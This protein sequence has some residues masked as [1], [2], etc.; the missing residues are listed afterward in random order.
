MF[1]VSAWNF[2]DPRV[3]EDYILYVSHKEGVSAQL[4]WNIAKCE[5]KFNPLAHNTNDPNGGSKGVFQF[6]T[7]TFYGFAEKY[8]IENPD[9]WNV[10][11]QV[12]IAIQMLKNNLAFHWTCSK[13]V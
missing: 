10:A 8:G 6:Q 11:Q 3:V 9:I 4:A 2:N 7:K 1:K 12:R 5:S 13:V